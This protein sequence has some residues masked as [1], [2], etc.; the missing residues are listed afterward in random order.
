ML[1][2]YVVTVSIAAA[3][4]GIYVRIFLATLGLIT[5]IEAGFYLIVG[6]GSLFVVTQCLWAA[7][8][9]ALNPTASN[10]FYVSE[11][12][13]HL[14]ALVFV[15]YILRVEVDWPH[16]ML[17]RGEPLV[18]LVVFLALHAVMKLAAFYGSLGGRAGARVTAL[19]W[20]GAAVFFA[21]TTYLG[22]GGWLERA[23]GEKPEVA[24]EAELHRA[25][26]AFAMA[27]LLPEGALYIAP[28]EAGA[29][30]D[31]VSL[32]WAA[33]EGAADG[34]ED[35]FVTVQ[36]QGEELK[37]WEDAVPIDVV[38]WQELELPST[39]LPAGADSLTVRWT[40]RPQPNWQRML[41]LN[42]VVFTPPDRDGKPQPPQQV[43]MAG[44][45]YHQVRPI[46][47]SY[48][49]L[50]FLIDGLNYDHMS[51][52]GYG[53]DTTPHIDKI[54]RA[55]T[56]YFNASSPSQHADDAAL[57]LLSGSNRGSHQPALLAALMAQRYA[58]AAFT[59]AE[60]ARVREFD[61]LHEWVES[62]EIYDPSYGTES[63]PGSR[64]T[65]TKVRNWIE[66]HQDETFAVFAR[67]RELGQLDEQEW[68][69]YDFLDKNRP[70][71]PIDTYDAA[72]MH[73]D[74][75]FGAVMAA[76]RESNRHLETIVV[77]AAPYR[78]RFSIDGGP[79]TSSGGYD[80]TNQLPVIISVPGQL[81]SARKTDITL[82]DLGVT[83]AALLNVP[84]PKADGTNLLLRG[85]D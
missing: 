79:I 3:L 72:L 56:V 17:A 55:G 42:P 69:N 80:A 48:N 59:E 47:K 45:Y 32:R 71:R 82:A 73:L 68:Y 34:L 50:V 35:V 51:F 57:S 61:R 12:A 84:L 78:Q 18:Y 7:F 20:L 5:G 21:G 37:V 23:A 85:G 13:S 54:A 70:K 4:L 8:C 63:T 36:V 19:G 28:V 40:S 75:Q 67:L 53:R 44:P 38:G 22:L 29:L 58:A 6:V 65:L 33:S 26:P 41:G 27:H 43:W 30:T 1:A 62:T 52:N 77:I 76:L 10:G 24:P 74:A 39:I 83:V 15:P 31:A 60:G 2:L 64:H 16:P 14:A 66:D 11:M 25:G 49:V 9:R 81:S 46:A